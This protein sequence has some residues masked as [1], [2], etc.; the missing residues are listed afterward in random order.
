MLVCDHQ[1]NV[2]CQNLFTTPH[3]IPSPPLLSTQPNLVIAN[4][5]SICRNVMDSPISNIGIGNNGITPDPGSCV[6]ILR[7][8]N[9]LVTN[10]LIC[11]G[12]SF[13]DKQKQTCVIGAPYPC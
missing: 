10:R 12:E 6:F 3:F 2:Q 5:S 11:P 13:F 7:C 9:G 1:D 4:I 8:H